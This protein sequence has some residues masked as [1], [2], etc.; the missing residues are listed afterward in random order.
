[1][2]SFAVLGQ[3]HHGRERAGLG[4]GFVATINRKHRRAEQSKRVESIFPDGIPVTTG[5]SVRHSVLGVEDDVY[6]VDVR[7]CTEFQ[8]EQVAELVVKQCKAGTPPEVIAALVAGVPLPIRA[9]L[10]SGVCKPLHFCL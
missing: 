4:A 7:R 8:L 2:S 3:L 9:G 10:I 6:F 5:D 1:M